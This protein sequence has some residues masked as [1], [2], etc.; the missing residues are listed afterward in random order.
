[1]VYTLFRPLF[2]KI[3]TPPYLHAQSNWAFIRKRRG[4]YWPTGNCIFQSR[5]IGKISGIP[6]NKG[7]S[8]IKLFSEGSGGGLLPPNVYQLKE[9]KD[10][11]LCSMRQIFHWAVYQNKQALRLKLTTFICAAKEQDFKKV[12]LPLVMFCSTESCLF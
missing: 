8:A 1:M 11:Q 5:A 3:D 4:F 7:P 12:L 2:I 6:V 10:L 9:V